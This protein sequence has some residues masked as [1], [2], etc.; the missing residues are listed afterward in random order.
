M[1]SKVIHIG[2]NYISKYLK[3]PLKKFNSFNN[4]SILKA[5]TN[6][7]ETIKN[8]SNSLFKTNT[9][10]FPTT[11]NDKNVTATSKSNLNTTKLN[12][13]ESNQLNANKTIKNINLLY[14]IKTNDNLVLDLGEKPYS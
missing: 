8:G 12:G 11:I 13:I 6:N 10:I 7:N 5:T 4:L 14:N 1:N 2:E 9:K 3:K